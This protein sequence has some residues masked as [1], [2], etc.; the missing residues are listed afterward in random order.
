VREAGERPASGR[1]VIELRWL[2]RGGYFPSS[3]SIICNNRNLYDP[4]S[5]RCKTFKTCRGLRGRRPAPRCNRRSRAHRLL[6]RD[7]PTPSAQSNDAAVEYSYDFC[8]CLS[9]KTDSVFD[10]GATLLVAIIH[11]LNL[12]SQDADAVDL[13]IDNIQCSTL[14]FQPSPLPSHP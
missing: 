6:P 5:V 8:F 11:A 12:L 7:A 14:T 9:E 2:P 10:K 1:N 13:E 3:I 4:G